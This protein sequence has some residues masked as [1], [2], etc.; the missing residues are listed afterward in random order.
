VGVAE[1]AGDRRA[2]AEHHL[3]F[4]GAAVP[5]EQERVGVGAEASL[6]VELLEFLGDRVVGLICQRLL[7]SPS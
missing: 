6:R 1:D 4:L 2:G 5:Q 3:E 7:L